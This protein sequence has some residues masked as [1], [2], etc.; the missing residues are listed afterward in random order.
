MG[1]IDYRLVPR[2]PVGSLGLLRP[3]D[4]VAAPAYNAGADAA[5]RRGY[6]QVTAGARLSYPF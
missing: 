5:L 2:G 6:P 4:T 1:A 3:N